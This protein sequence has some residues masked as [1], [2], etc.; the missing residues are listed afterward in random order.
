MRCIYFSIR[1]IM[2]F[3]SDGS[4]FRSKFFHNNYLQC[5][6]KIVPQ[7]QKMKKKEAD[8][9]VKFDD[10]KK[11]IKELRWCHVCWCRCNV[12]ILVVFLQS[13]RFIAL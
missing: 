6:L 7:F 1:D 13:L 5:I 9:K 3:K 10:A 4:D 12:N 8:S 2:V 11:E